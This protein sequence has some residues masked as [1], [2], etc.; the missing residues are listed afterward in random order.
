MSKIDVHLHEATRILEELDKCRQ[1]QDADERK[2]FSDRALEKLRALRIQIYTQDDFDSFEAVANDVINEKKALFRTI[3]EDGRTDPSVKQKA[4]EELFQWIESAHKHNLELDPEI[5]KPL[6]ELCAK[7]LRVSNN[8]VAVRQPCGQVLRLVLRLTKNDRDKAEEKEKDDKELFGKLLRELKTELNKATASKQVKGVVMSVLGTLCERNSSVIGSWSDPAIGPLLEEFLKYLQRRLDADETSSTQS[9]DLVSGYLQA[10][11][12]YLNGA[13]EGQTE[14]GLEDFLRT[15]YGRLRLI[16]RDAG[17][18]S[19]YKA[20][21]SALEL[22]KEHASRF[23]AYVLHESETKEFYTYLLELCVHSNSDVKNP[24]LEATEAWLGQ[25][26]STLKPEGDATHHEATLLQLWDV[27]TK[28]LSEN[29][30]SPSRKV[31]L[32]CLAL[33]GYGTLSKA[34]KVRWDLVPTWTSL[35]SEV[36]L[37]LVSVVDNA[38]GSEEQDLLP[39][40]IISL[41]DFLLQLSSEISQADLEMLDG[42]CEALLKE[43]RTTLNSRRF[44]FERAFYFLL[45]ALHRRGRALSLFLDRSMYRN[46]ITNVQPALTNEYALPGVSGAELD[47]RKKEQP[48]FRFSEFWA[49]SFSKPRCKHDSRPHCMFHK[50][51]HACQAINSELALG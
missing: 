30:D 33:R 20:V 16:L 32:K 7:Q 27:C 36:K 9:V 25:V 17:D 1:Y 14:E 44:L 43:Y 28:K 6:R 35:A 15:V 24:A 34:A 42:T 48:C 8:T 21:I 2:D 40:L 38:M 5:L 26:A 10:V 18:V 41:S 29:P 31:R 37:V 22:L 49:R 51:T 3:K 47:S 45:Y 50:V 19:R 13:S 39:D 46:V 4:C 12:G 23:R 11:H